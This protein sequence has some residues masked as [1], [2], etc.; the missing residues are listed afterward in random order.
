MNPVS[1]NVY[2]EGSGN[3][4][5]KPKKSEDRFINHRNGLSAEHP[6]AVDNINVTV[7]PLSQLSELSRLLFGLLDKVPLS[8]TKEVQQFQKLSIVKI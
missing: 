7:V 2:R 4:K 8:L 3:V 1:H 5:P 6:P